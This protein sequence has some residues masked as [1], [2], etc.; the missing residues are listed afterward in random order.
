MANIDANSHFIIHYP[1]ISGH[2]NFPGLQK[3]ARVL[4]HKQF[5]RQV[6]FFFDI[7]QREIDVEFS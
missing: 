5:V 7:L 2:E 3:K 6:E 4:S 1:E